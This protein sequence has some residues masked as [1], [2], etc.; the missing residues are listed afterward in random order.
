MW[1]AERRGD[2]PAQGKKHEDD[3]APLSSRHFGASGAAAGA[4]GVAL[5]THTEHEVRAVFSYGA[6]QKRVAPHQSRAAAVFYF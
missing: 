6:A 2:G 4:I 3:L 1:I 5:D